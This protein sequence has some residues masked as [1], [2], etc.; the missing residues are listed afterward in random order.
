VNILS[1]SNGN[2]NQIGLSIIR[3]RI[4][5]NKNWASEISN[6]QGASKRGAQVMATPWTAPAWMKTN[7]N[8]NGGSL[9]TDQYQ[10]LPTI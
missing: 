6:A 3:L 2:N 5:P 9:K 7:N 10:A 4:D 8:V 1:F